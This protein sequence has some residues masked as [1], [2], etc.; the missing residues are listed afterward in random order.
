MNK[1]L[2]IGGIAVA[3]A[4]TYGALTFTPPVSYDTINWVRPNTDAKW[5]EDVKREN[6][7][8]KS[9]PVL[10]V[11][12]ESHSAKLERQLKEDKVL[13]CPEC[14]RYELRKQ[15]EASGMTGTELDTEVENQY[16]TQLKNYNFE[17]EKLKQSLERMEKEIDLRSRGKVNRQYND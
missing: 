11:M 15:F 4:I 3:G 14:V 12:I 16:Q 5:A 7:D 13:A 10:E 8:I 2:I 6:F 9:T 1:T 17:I